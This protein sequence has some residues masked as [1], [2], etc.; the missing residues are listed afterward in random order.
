MPSPIVGSRSTPG[1][2]PACPQICSVRNDVRPRPS[3]T[4]AVPATI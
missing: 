1:E 2:L 4:I 3:S